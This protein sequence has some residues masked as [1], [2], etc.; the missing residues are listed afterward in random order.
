M[1][2][3]IIQRLSRWSHKPVDPTALLFL[4][5][6]SVA[7]CSANKGS[8]QTA[9]RVA[10]TPGATAGAPAVPDMPACAANNPFCGKP[11]ED[12]TVLAPAMTLPTATQTKQADCGE[13]PTDI[14][15]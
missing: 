8:Q 14:T 9:S 15:P 3:S 13:L 7:A 5:L 1:S 10:A 4:L 12:P 11:A 2:L 6:I